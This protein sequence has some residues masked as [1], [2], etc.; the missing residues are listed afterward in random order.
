[1]SPSKQCRS[2][3]PL[4]SDNIIGHKIT[5]K[6]L[7]RSSITKPFLLNG[8]TVSSE[9]FMGRKSSI[10]EYFPLPYQC[11]QHGIPQ[12]SIAAQSPGMFNGYMLK[13][14]PPRT[15]LKVT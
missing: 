10:L 3:N 11:H 13:D 1:M 7:D 9:L 8:W 6:N 5:K 2:P 4:S 14:S 15:T 12:Y